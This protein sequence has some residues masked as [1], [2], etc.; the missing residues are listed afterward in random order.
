YASA[1]Q[2]CEL[3]DPPL[4]DALPICLS[5][6]SA[7]AGAAR[8]AS[9]VAP[10]SVSM[11]LFIAFLLSGLSV[12]CDLRAFGF[13]R[14]RRGAGARSRTLERSEEHTSELQSREKL[15]CRLLLE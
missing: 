4:P 15:V 9:A 10:A 2:V 7:S 3:S 12:G 14:H 11:S 8:P 13:D 6:L 5:V 1:R